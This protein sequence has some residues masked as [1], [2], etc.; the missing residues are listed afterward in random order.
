MM[1]ARIVAMAPISQVNMRAADPGSVSLPYII[2]VA[3]SCCA[4]SVAVRRCSGVEYVD[5]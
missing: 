4:S 3:A 1:A 2:V 5:W